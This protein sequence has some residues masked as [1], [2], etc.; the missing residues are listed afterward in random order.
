MKNIN[1]S[2]RYI[3]PILIVML[4]TA[5]STTPE[6]GIDSIGM[7]TTISVDETMAWR[8]CLF[9]ITWPEDTEPNLVIDLLLAHKIVAPVLTELGNDIDRWRFHRRASRDYAGHQFSFL[10]YTGSSLSKKITDKIQQNDLTNQLL[11]EKILEKMVCNIPEDISQPG[12]S[13][14][15]DPTWSET[16]QK[17]WPSYIMGVSNLWLGL[18]DDAIVSLGTPEIDIDSMVQQYSEANDAITAI[19]QQEGRHAFLHHINAI[20][21]YEEMLIRF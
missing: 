2:K 13:D 14:T 21:G 9:K 3:P 7:V 10:F 19:W 8:R 12:I 1:F 18:I 4:L 5:C 15:S 6:R 16:V 11:E 17:N 20:F